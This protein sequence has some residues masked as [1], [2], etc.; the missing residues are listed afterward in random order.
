MSITRKIGAVLLAVF[1]AVLAGA[2]V[3]LEVT[4]QPSFERQDI[5]AHELDRARVQANIE[6][7]SDDLYTRAA[8]YAVWDE[9]YR[10]VSGPH[11][12]YIRDNIANPD[13]LADYG[14]DLAIFYADDG[15][16]LWSRQWTAQGPAEA[17][18]V[19]RARIHNQLRQQPDQDVVRGALWSETMGPVLFVAMRATT[20]DG[21]APRRGYV[22]F[23]RR[24]AAGALSRQTQLELEFARQGRDRDE[25]PGSIVVTHDALQSSIP[26]LAPN[27]DVVGAVIARSSRLVSAAG[28]QTLGAAL[29]LAAIV[30]GAGLCGVWLLLRRV[31]I[32]RVERIERHFRLQRNAMAPLPPDPAK[33]EIASLTAAYNE[34]ARRLGVADARMREALL[35]TAAADAANRM[36]SNFLANISYELRTPLNDVIGYADLVDEE[37]ADRGDTGARPDLQRI[38]G[39]ARSMLSLLSELLDLSRIEAGGLELAPESFEV[40]E[41]FREAAAAVRA[42]AKA[43]GADLVVHAPSNLGQAYTDQNRL[44]QCLV[45]VLAHAGRRSRGGAFALRGQRIRRSDGD[46]LR[47]TVHDSGPRLTPAQIEG[48]F[49]PFLRE[50]DERLSGARLGLAVTRKLI[51]LMGGGIEVT[52]Q[53][54][55]CVYVL[56]APA[57]LTNAKGE[58]EDA[59][60]APASAA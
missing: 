57:L 5:A 31:V 8:D 12:T 10:F 52:S 53:E 36:K 7:I 27:G 37:L 49:E 21:S 14:A 30:I 41:V 55:G 58:D 19:L 3:I 32:D 11:P 38:T 34:L 23:G 17:L 50:D 25:P 59:V 43:N 45:N 33:D 39:A 2:W 40:E 16:T 22:V 15:R 1:A 4:V 35:Q 18:L 56:T 44:R 47:F 6:A 60:S 20:T 9:T 13:W 46:T 51:E 29:A 26:L 48:L 54:S 24:L 42:S 28:E